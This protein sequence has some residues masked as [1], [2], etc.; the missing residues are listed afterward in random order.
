MQET[1]MC[2]RVEMTAQVGAWFQGQEG[3]WHQGGGLGFRKR[4]GVWGFFTSGLGSLW[5]VAGG[6]LA[7]GG[8]RVAGD[9]GSALGAGLRSMSWGGSG[10]GPPGPCYCSL[11]SGMSAGAAW[12]PVGW[13]ALPGARFR[14]MFF[15]LRQQLSWIYKF[16]FNGEF[17]VSYKHQYLQV[18]MELLDGGALTDVVTE[19]V[20]KEKS[21]VQV[22]LLA[23]KEDTI[24][25]AFLIRSADLKIVETVDEVKMVASNAISFLASRVCESI[26]T[27]R[28]RDFLVFLATLG[29]IA[30]RFGGMLSEGRLAAADA[31]IIHRDIK[32]DNILLGKDGSVKVTDFGFCA[33]I[34]G[35]EKR[36]T[37]VGTPYW[38]APE[39][40]NRKQ[41][42]KKV[43]IWS[44]GIM[45]IEMVEGEPPYLKET[46]LRALYLIAANGKPEIP[47]WS[48]LSSEFQVVTPKMSIRGDMG[49]NMDTTINK[50]ASATNG[51]KLNSASY[52]LF[53]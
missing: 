9:L 45:A 12:G 37:M 13:W 27:S 10:A 33:N 18:V 15:L 1:T 36:Q 53:K 11:G 35:D 41:Y 51:R 34:S 32:S 43:D 49:P 38:M 4:C 22:V 50:I 16:S 6:L 52:I 40:V 2:A 5:S 28:V 39:V 14:L 29:D 7:S 20:M 30:G 46:P 42:G 31:G 19:T 17:F 3:A 44:L 23:C 25:P 21:R 48:K 24:S 26:F 47:S 8:E